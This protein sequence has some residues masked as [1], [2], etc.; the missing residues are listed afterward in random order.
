MMNAARQHTRCKDAIDRIRR[1]ISLLIVLFF[2][3]RGL[4]GQA[5]LVHHYT[6]MEGLSSAN[7]FGITQDHWGR[8]WF[9]TRGGITVYDGTNWKTYT[10]SDG[11]PVLAFFGIQTDRKK[12]TVPNGIVCRDKNR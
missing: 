4:S 2:I 9:A 8:V 7:V 1:R 10:I 12:I 6:E 3:S 11:L 5:Y